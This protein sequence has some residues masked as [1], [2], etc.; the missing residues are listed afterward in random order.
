MSINFAIGCR[1]CG[2][3]TMIESYVDCHTKRSLDIEHDIHIDT[4]CAIR[5]PNCRARLNSSEAEFRSQVR[6]VSKS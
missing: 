3:H 5:C 6:V 1:N 4:E 2:T